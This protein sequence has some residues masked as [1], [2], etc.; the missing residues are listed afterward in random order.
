MPV[1]EIDRKRAHD[2]NPGRGAGPA[3]VSGWRMP[4]GED[5]LHF[6]LSAGLAAGVWWLERREEEAAGALV[7]PPEAGPA[8]EES[9]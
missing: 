5:L 2:S 4:G 1:A 8:S 9:R 7:S 6:A 3:P